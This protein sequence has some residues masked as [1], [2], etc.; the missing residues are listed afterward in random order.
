MVQFIQIQ[1]EDF[2]E[3]V[4][5]SQLFT[6]CK[7]L[8]CSLVCNLQSHMEVMKLLTVSSRADEKLYSNKEK[9]LNNERNKYDTPCGVSLN[10][11]SLE[12]KEDS[13]NICSV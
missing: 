1:V 3:E 4:S 12:P 7:E 11:Y 9:I 8:D 10:Q 2:L 13:E 6:I 5:L